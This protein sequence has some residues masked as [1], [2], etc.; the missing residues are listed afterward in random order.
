MG[1][2]LLGAILYIVTVN[3]MPVA[4]FDTF[5]GMNRWVYDYRANHPNLSEAGR[6]DIYKCTTRDMVGEKCL[7]YKTIS[8]PT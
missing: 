8:Q 6:V 2:L 4:T 3:H 5:R 7:A 1:R